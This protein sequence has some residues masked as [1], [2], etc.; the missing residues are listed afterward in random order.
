MNTT[1]IQKRSLYA[2]LQ[3]VKRIGKGR[4]KFA[5]KYR[6]M[7]QREMEKCKDC[8][9]VWIMPLNK[10]IEN[11]KLNKNLFDVVIFD[12]SSQSDIFGLSALMRGKRA[13]IV[14]DDKQISPQA[15]GIGEE[16][17]DELIDR[18]LKEIPHSEWFDLQTSLYNT[19]LRVFPDRLLLREHFRCAPEIIG[20]SNNLSYSGEIIPLRYPRGR[21]AFICPIKAVK[22]KNGSKDNMSQVNMNEAKEIVDQIVKCCNN[23]QYDNMTMGVISLLGDQQAEIIENLLRHSLVRENF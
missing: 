22:V 11:I 4:G 5:L 10:V 6:N 20:F 8:I 13:V 16:N 9:P 21:E 3:A 23:P 14:G 1:D 12:E 15:V 18:H 2:W 19:A 7:A 17:I